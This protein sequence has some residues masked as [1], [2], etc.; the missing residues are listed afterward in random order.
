MKNKLFII[1]AVV[2]I[3]ILGFALFN[4]EKQNGFTS[5]DISGLSEAQ[6]AKVVNLK[7][8]DTYNLTANIVK[9]KIAGREVK[10]LA[11]N[12]SIP[13]PILKAPQG[14]E[15]TINFTNNID[16]PT[17]IHSHGIRLDNE[18]DGV[19]GSTQKEVGIGETFS[20][21]I[22]FPDTGVYWYHPHLREDYAQEL[23]LYGNYIVSPADQT[24]WPAANREIPLVIDD[25][26]MENGEIAPFGETVDH[27]LM[28]RFGNVMLVNGS[29]SYALSVEQEEVV[30]F[31]VT[32][33]ANTRV[34]NLAI[35][36]AKMKLVG[37]D[38][39]R[40]EKESFVNSIVLGPSERAV[41]DVL[42]EKPG[43]FSLEH[44]TPSKTYIMGKISVLPHVIA[45]SYKEQ[46]T[47]LRSN[48]DIRKAIPNLDSY[49]SKAADKNISLTVNMGSMSMNGSHAM[50]GGEMMANNGMHM[51][52]DG[53]MMNSEGMTMG[54][55]DEDK[56]EWEDTMAMMN[57]MSYADSVQWKITDQDTGKTGDNINWT[58]KKGDLVK[59]RIFNDPN[60]EHPMQHPIH[61]HGQRF[62]VLSTNG[63][64][65]QNLVWKDTAL[66]E[67]GDTVQILVEMD[68]LGEW[69]AH[70][71]ISEHLEAG[72]MLN[73]K[74]Q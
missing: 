27:A 48:N 43:Q 51:M 63:E 12:G 61:F 66:I 4:T 23:G 36:G 67:K 11:Y 19:P 57:E 26:L 70:C 37:G 74:V 20:Y 55:S 29:D 68:N 7:N 9:K 22:K 39:G 46:F 13:G 65:N 42:F 17:T 15:I 44:K 2:I 50:H 62:L 53:T 49:F 60:S 21:K 52:P 3:G 16:A 34:F 32:N 5:P 69:M 71:H 28:G 24:Y 72:M 56:I 1:L 10:M 35:P 6:E 38:N 58:F 25:L 14:S 59:I 45:K 64:R 54:G 31:Y 30:R 33:T 8:G 18:F 41:I 40:Y 47:T 73:F